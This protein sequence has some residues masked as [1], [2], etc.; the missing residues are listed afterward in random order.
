MTR[1]TSLSGA[2]PRTFPADRP[3]RSLLRDNGL[4]IALLA[5]FAFPFAGIALPRLFATSF[6]LPL[7]GSDRAAAEE[8]ILHGAQAPSLLVG[9]LARAQVWCESV[10]NWQSGCLATATPV[11]LS[12]LLRFR[13]AP[14]S[15]HVEAGNGE[16]GR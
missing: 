15:R 3:R 7:R 14:G 6:A 13:G 4:T 1:S 16:T 5:L 9:H 11:L 10:R 12:I 8:T 2:E